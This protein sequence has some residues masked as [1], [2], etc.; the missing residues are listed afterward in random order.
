[1]T[2]TPVVFPTITFFMTAMLAALS[3]MVWVGLAAFRTIE[4]PTALAMTLMP[5][6]FSTMAQAE[7]VTLQMM[8]R[9]TVLVKMAMLAALLTIV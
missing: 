4:R 1:M 7:M 5:A 8:E 2:A 9:P 3:T 6:A